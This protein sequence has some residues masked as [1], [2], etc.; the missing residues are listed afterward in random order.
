MFS[1]FKESNLLRQNTYSR[2]RDS[3]RKW[4]MCG[5]RLNSLARKMEWRRW[6]RFP[7]YCVNWVCNTLM[8]QHVSARDW[9]DPCLGQ[10]PPGHSELPDADSISMIWP[11]MSCAR[12][13]WRE[14]SAELQ[15]W[16]AGTRATTLGT[17]SLVPGMALLE[18]I[19]YRQHLSAGRTCAELLGAQESGQTA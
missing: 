3:A 10:P 18:S 1:I 14:R 12:Q 13:R 16:P 4:C 11:S 9:W 8:E 2:S 5:D 17:V 7:T 15:Q 6:N 19:S